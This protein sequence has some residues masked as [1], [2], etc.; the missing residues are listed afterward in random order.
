M[1]AIAKDSIVLVTGCNGFI[2]SHIVD[3]L[4]KA[5]YNVRGTTRDLK[6]VENL[7]KIWK[8]KY[9]SQKFEVLVVP[10]MAEDGAFDE[11]VKG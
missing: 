10:E 4:L 9:G 8:E 2:G 5:G 11:A 3:Q 6:K 7:A 1:A